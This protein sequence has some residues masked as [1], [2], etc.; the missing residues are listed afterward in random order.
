ME[1]LSFWL[2]SEKKR[3]SITY[4][5]RRH[6]NNLIH[7]GILLFFVAILFGKVS[8]KLEDINQVRTLTDNEMQ[9]TVRTFGVDGLFGYFGKYHTPGIGHT[10][11]YATQQKNKILI[12]TNNDNKIVITPDDIS[13]ANKL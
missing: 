3:K 9:G 1:F 13:L 6:N 7:T 10:T 4:G 12:V 2:Q 11:F 5:T 8:I